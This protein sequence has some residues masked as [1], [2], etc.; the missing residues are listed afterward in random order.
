MLLR[1]LEKTG[2]RFH[3]TGAKFFCLILFALAF[4]IFE[5]GHAKSAAERMEMEINVIMPLFVERSEQECPDCTSFRATE[6][7]DFPDIRQ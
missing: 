1:F 5:I 7:L 2:G 4:Q 6:S 3:N